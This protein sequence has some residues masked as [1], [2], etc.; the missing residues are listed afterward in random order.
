MSDHHTTRSTTPA[1]PSEAWQLA[2]RQKTRRTRPLFVPSSPSTSAHAIQPDSTP[3]TPDLELPLRLS[4]P[5]DEVSTKKPLATCTFLDTR[6]TL[7]NIVD[8][9]DPAGVRKHK[10]NRGALKIAMA[11]ALL[12]SVQP[13]ELDKKGYELREYLGSDSIQIKMHQQRYNISSVAVQSD[14]SLPTSLATPQSTSS[15]PDNTTT[16]SGNSGS[17]ERRLSS[18]EAKLDRLLNHSTAPAAPASSKKSWAQAAAA[19]TTTNKT[20]APPAATKPDTTTSQLPNSKVV[21]E[22]ESPLPAAIDATAFRDTINSCLTSREVKSSKVIAVSRS[23]KGNLKIQTIRDAT[24]I[25]KKQQQWISKLALRARTIHDDSTWE[26]RILHLP[27]GL[28]SPQ[29]LQ[30]ELKASNNSIKLAQPPRLLSPKVAL[31]C[32]NSRATTPPKS[33]FAFAQELKL[34]MYRP[35]T[36]HTSSTSTQDSAP[37]MELD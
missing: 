15:T 33:V 22:L 6:V 1:G 35:K 25:I 18:L 29:A 19:G 14:T 32:F 36:A 27:T 7:Y 31:L 4:V 3:S 20:T 8:A 12:D 16:P 11:M 2:G 13:T 26:K 5:A 37:T 24:P 30:Q 10:T 28:D 21:V 17:V 9:D 34:V 23:A